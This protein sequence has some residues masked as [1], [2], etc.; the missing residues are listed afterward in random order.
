VVNEAP[1]TRDALMAGVKARY[2]SE[3][4]IAL[5]TA[6]FERLEAQNL[7]I[8]LSFRHLA[9]LL[10]IGSPKLRAIA[11]ATDL[12]YR[13]FNIPKRSGGMREISA[14]L[15]DLA[16]IQRWIT[17]NILVRLTSDLSASA[18]AYLPG[19][20]IV[21]HVAPHLSSQQLLKL[22]L[23]DFFPSVTTSHVFKIFR[24]IGYATSVART[25]A[26]LTTVNGSL[27]QGAPSSPVLSN[28]ALKAFD[29]DIEAMCADA[30]LKYTRYA[31]DIVISGE[32]VTNLQ[33]TVA[34]IADVYGFKINHR[35]SKAYTNPHETRFVTGLMIQNG[36]ARV[37]KSARRLI[38]AQVHHYMRV[39]DSFI[40]EGRT[41]PP[42]ESD[43]RHPADSFDDILFPERLIGRLQFWCWVESDNPYPKRAISCLKENLSRL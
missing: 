21:D 27:P 29:A 28:I 12:F 15:H 34:K 9:D 2:K 31:D 35:K 16:I 3:T 8:I 36:R 17:S 26:A 41:M 37:P 13:S 24:D 32:V 7:P 22:D 23:R 39:L 20:S 1:Y 40:D 11:Y 4:K 19:R 30:E 6:Y 43:G 25:L 42:N 38:R 33:N 10:N 14:P 5:Y 18:M